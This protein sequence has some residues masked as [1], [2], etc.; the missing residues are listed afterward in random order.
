MTNLGPHLLGRKP[1]PDSRHL[2]LHPY[3][4][5]APPQGIEV[6]IK[7]PTLSPYDQGQTPECVAFSTSK[8]VNHF[9][10]YAFDAPWLYARCKEIDGDP[11]GEGTNARFACDVLRTKGHWRMISG[12]DVKAGPSLKH[13]I[14]SN[15]WATTVDDIRS[16]FASAKPQPV[17]IGIDWYEAWFQ[18][19][20]SRGGEW[21]LQS[22][23]QAGGVAGGHEIGI[24]AC[25]DSRQSFGLSNTWGWDWPGGHDQL[26]W[27]P[28]NTMAQLFGADADACVI[29][30]LASR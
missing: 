16:V 19:A 8:I 2:E 3:D 12:K 17:P 20:E 4:A 18:P 1:A 25:S 5:A 21:A 7:R 23:A 9:N 28:F 10:G 26:V 29:Q 24:W 27:L 13:G 15:S 30:D 22:P 11:T 6:N 14:T